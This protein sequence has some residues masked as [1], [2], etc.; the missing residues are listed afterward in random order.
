MQSVWIKNVHVD[1]KSLPKIM[2]GVNQEEELELV[3]TVM[4]LLSLTSFMMLLLSCPISMLRKSH[5]IMT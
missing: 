5:G 3:I 4:I 2:L 1:S